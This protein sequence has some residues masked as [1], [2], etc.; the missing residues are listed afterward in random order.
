M[1]AIVVPRPGGTDDLM[2]MDVPVPDIEEGQALV[3]IHAIGV[4]LHDRWFMPKDIRFPY[5]IG[6]EAAGVVERVSATT[7]F[8][9]G[10]R[11]MFISKMQPKGG[12]WAELAAVRES[13]MVAIPDPL[14]FIR[15]AALPVAGMTAVAALNQT[16]L[17]SNQCLFVAGA[18][19]AIGTLLL[20]LARFREVGVAGSASPANHEYV[21][22]LGAEL[23]V[24]YRDPHWIEQ[25]RQW[26]PQGVEA[27][28]AIPPGTTAD[29]LPV[30]Q[31][32]GQL[33]AISGDQLS[34]QRQIHVEQVRPSEDIKPSLKKLADLTASRRLHVEIEQ[35]YPFARAVEA[36]EKT[37]TRHARGKV[38]ISL[39]EE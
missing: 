21:R 15:A 19:G 17:E 8:N 11:V 34:S 7:R 37:E 39:I 25:V 32:G 1:K 35:V 4:G 2:L 5:P 14:D 26:R 27:A 36:L 12:V 33:I 30:I 13:E 38:V 20:Q 9:P 29:C 28:I 10:Q 24:D 31:D 3:R 18:S 23:A 16:T 6:I 22:S